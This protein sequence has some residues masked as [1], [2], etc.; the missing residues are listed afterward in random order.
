MA[1]KP[2]N[3]I[4][5]KIAYVGCTTARTSPA[6]AVDARSPSDR[7]RIVS[8]ASARAAG[9]SSWRDAVAGSARNTYAPPAPGAKQIIATCAAAVTPAAHVLLNSAQPASKA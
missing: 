6:A 2:T 5:R 3:G 1:R 7:E 9:T 4:Q 8:R